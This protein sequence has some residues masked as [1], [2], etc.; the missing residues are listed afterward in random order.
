MRDA[1]ARLPNGNGSLR[2]IAELLSESQYITRFKSISKLLEVVVYCLPILLRKTNRVYPWTRIP[3]YFPTSNTGLASTIIEH[4]TNVLWH[5]R[6]IKKKWNPKE[7]SRLTVL[8]LK[9][10]DTRKKNPQRHGLHK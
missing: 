10:N 3:V 6:I 4:W 7:T 9:S 5:H 8:T 1:I 2:K